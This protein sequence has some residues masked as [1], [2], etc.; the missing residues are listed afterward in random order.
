MKSC[1]SSLAAFALILGA[2]PAGASPPPVSAYGRLPAISSVSLSPSGQF[3]ASIN[4]VEGKRYILVRTLAGETQLAVPIGENKVRGIQWADDGHL[5]VRVSK[6]SYFRYETNEVEVPTTV[7]IDVKARKSAILF[8]HN[9]KFSVIYSGQPH[10]YQI[11]GH[12]YAFV[13]NVPKEGQVGITRLQSETDGTFIRNFPDLWKIDLETNKI[14]LFAHG[15]PDIDGWVV[16]PTTDSVAAYANFD[17]N[18]STWTLFHGAKP[19]MSKQSQRLAIDLIGLGRTP[20]SVLVLDQTNGDKLIEVESDGTVQTLSE[21]KPI[22]EYYFSSTTGL[23]QGVQLRDSDLIFYDPQRRQRMAA[24]GRAFPGKTVIFDSWTDGLD[25]VVLYTDGP[26]DAGTFYLVNMN[27]HRADVLD[28]DFPGIPSDQVGPVRLYTY[29][30]SD[31]MSLDGVLTL[32]PGREAKALP[33][34]VLPHGGPIGIYDRAEFDWMAQAFASRGYA[35]FQPNYRGSGDHGAAYQNAGFGEF[36]RKMLTDMSDGLTSLAKD[37][38]VDPKRACIVGFSYGGYAAMAGVTVQQ[39][40]YRCAVAG[41][42]ISDVPAMMDWVFQRNGS[43]SAALTFW[44]QQTGVGVP[45][46]PSLG[47][48][49]P[50]ALARRADAPLLLI[51]GTEDSVVPFE[52]SK[53]MLNAM[54]N[55]GKPVQLITTKGEDHWLSHEDTRI[56][57]LTAALDFVQKH[58]PPD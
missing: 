27:T 58:N 24:L 3:M 54:T 34:V 28:N 5:L 53:L 14:E 18:S 25:E 11:G 48:I 21:N 1:L 12:P 26:G 17:Q 42:G 36:G 51:H 55:A 50:V 46:A 31:G 20:G 32:P 22:T 38:V 13:T 47:S 45:G 56:Q 40:L 10:A 6:A 9:P 33:V 39:G 57:T 19:L 7:S 37:G 2:T 43:P 4:D 52:Q 44:R 8:D 41:S 35:V 29:K 23:L 49:S 30:A 15:S 16:D